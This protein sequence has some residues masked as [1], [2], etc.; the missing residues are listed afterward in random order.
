MITKMKMII[1]IAMFCLAATVCLTGCGTEDSAKKTTG[2]AAVCFAIAPT[3]NSQGLNMDS[4]IVQD[5]ISETILGYGYIS[6]AVV[7]GN[8]EIVASDSYDIDPQ[9]KNASKQRLKTDAKVKTADLLTFMKS[10]A[11]NDPQVDYLEGLR[12]AARSLNSLEG[13]GSKTIVVVGTGL[14]TQGTLNFQ[15]N[16]LSAEPDY[17]LD[18]LEEKNEIP[19]LEGITVVW[20]QMG[21]VASPQQE[22]SQTQR[23]RL[24]NIWKGLVERGGGEFVPDDTMPNPV[25]TEKSY[26][27]VDTVELPAE[28]P[29]SFDENIFE[30]K[31]ASLL[32][33]P[34]ML[35]EEQ[36]SFV[37]DKAAYLDEEAAKTTI[38]PIAEYLLANRQITILLA[39]T[40]AGDEDSDYTMALSQNRADAVKNTLTAMGVDESRIIAVGLGSNDPWHIYGG[41]CEGGIASANRKVVLLDASSDTAK[42]ILK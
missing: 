9:Y 18:L 7:D 16:L 35:T 36:V 1:F 42:D 41:G 23:K 31:D 6:V 24:Q 29:V 15:N 19:N 2:P 14:S 10:Q 33:A 21:D 28:T 32:K 17:V 8:T 39:G 25:D 27:E 34:V 38:K 20:Q 3:A 4:L 30:I 22:L 13:Y 37:P 40:T 12:K 5:T 11:A 26:P